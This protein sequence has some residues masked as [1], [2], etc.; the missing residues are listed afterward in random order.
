MNY[1]EAKAKADAL[2]A[3]YTAKGA[4]LN[5]FLARFP[6]GPMGLPLDEVKAM[7]EYRELKAACDKALAALRNYNAW[8]VKTFAKERRAA[9]AARFQPA[10]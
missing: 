9:A 5:Q 3:D 10:A 6:K 8:Y 1:L 7:P 2:N 4:A